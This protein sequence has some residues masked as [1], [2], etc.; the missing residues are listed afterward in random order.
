MRM[1][2]LERDKESEKEKE[3]EKI[4]DEQKVEFEQPNKGDMKD[5]WRK[6]DSTIGHHTIRPGATTAN[7]TSRPVSMAE[8]F[9]S[10]HTIVPSNQRLSALITD[11][12]YGMLEEDDDESPKANIRPLPA[13]SNAS[14]ASSLCTKNRRSMSLNLDTQTFLKPQPLLYSSNAA[15][16]DYKQP[17]L[18][19]S[20]GVAPLT[21]PVPMRETPTLTRADAR[22]FISPSYVSPQSTS[23]IRGRLAAWTVA[24]SQ[25]LSSQP[26]VQQE[27]TLPA[28]PSHSHRAPTPTQPSHPAPLFRQTAISMSNGLAPAAGLAKRAVEKMGRVWGMSSSSS[29][30][31]YSSSSSSIAA[32]SSF[33]SASHMDHH[34]TRTT[35]NQ[36]NPSIHN[37]LQYKRRTPNH[38][39]SSGTHSV[40]S[41]IASGSPS[42]SD[43]FAPPPGPVLG[44]MMR[45]PL[46]NKLGSAASGKVVFGRELKV[47]V[48]ETRVW[49]GQNG[50]EEGEE[51]VGRVERGI[52]LRALEARTVPALVARCAQH[53]LIWGVQEEGLFRCVII[54]FFL[55]I[56]T[57]WE[58]HDG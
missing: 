12:D 19:I 14:P 28:L 47:V 41:S 36:S 4:K 21:T 40:S 16:I 51:P 2:E 6:S 22:G 7:R 1:G 34:L 39:I 45:G 54:S 20:E 32:P 38:N 23:N 15:P 57:Q 5:V 55:Y 33:T 42:E 50:K 30:S 17:S 48:K 24:N 56:S 37:P 25:S 13:K 31:G 27:R 9:Q 43:P 49:V 29:S 3:R 8:S 11:A 26:H 52:S 44:K 46:R 35:S 58:S 10:S 53:L 18:S